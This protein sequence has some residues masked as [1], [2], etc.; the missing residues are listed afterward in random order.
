MAE[1]NLG[2]SQKLA[3]TAEIVAMDELTDFDAVQTVIYG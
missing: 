2:L 1:Y 3:E